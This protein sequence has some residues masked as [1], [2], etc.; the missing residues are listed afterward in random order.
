[1]I[2]S[3][4]KRHG[5]FAGMEKK[6]N[7]VEIRLLLAFGLAGVV[8]FVSQYFLKPAAPPT[9]AVQTAG[10]QAQPAKPSEA[11]S[12]VTADKP[13]PS[14][15]P[16]NGK[17][18]AAVAAKEIKADK[19]ETV[20]VETNRYL[21][22]FSN[23][24][25]VAR[26]WILKSF[27]DSKGKP[28]DVVDQQSLGK[29]PDVFSVAFKGQAPATDINGQLFKMER[30][31]DG[32]G[33]TF[34]YSDGMLTAHKAFRF[35]AQD[36]LVKVTSNI[37]ASGAALLH[38]IT[39]RGG[40]GDFTVISATAAQHTSRY[41]LTAEKLESQAVGDAK[42]GPISATGQYSF[43]AI[44][45]A[46]FAA[47]FLPTDKVAIEQTTYADDIPNSEGKA[48]PHVGL[49]VGNNGLNQ[50]SLFVGPKDT[51]LLEKVDPKLAQIVDWGWF[52]I[53]ARPLFNILAWTS[54]E[55]THNYGWAI[56]VVTIGINFLLFPGRLSGIKSSKKMQAIQPQVKAINDKYKNLGMRDPR[57]SEQ[58][59]ELMELYKKHDISV[60]GGC[61]PLLI[62]IPFLYAFYKVLSLSTEMRG[63]EWLWVSDLSRPET[64]ALR[65]LPLLL[66]ITQFLQQ[67]MTPPA[68]G[69][70]PS[71]Q[72][73]MMMM[74]LVMGFMFY[75][76]SSGLVLYWLTGNIVGIGQQWI[77]N[78]L[79]HTP[80][81]ETPKPGTSKK[82]RS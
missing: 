56:I 20:T 37:T 13:V 70:D 47:V 26:S 55:L 5:I 22:T 38:S 19:E 10:N 71:Q 78:K 74:P 7:S 39:W 72:K 1:M 64:L 81:V 57:K 66:I 68:P 48:E 36:Y 28:L 62:Q 29:V 58:Q 61:L 77:L 14:A 30:S 65:A 52:G 16:V 59:Q 79:T 18:P 44:E 60:A 32:L 63:A 17:T 11:A 80:A 51:K 21:V 75:G 41:D 12:P 45:D 34:D 4:S 69:M 15:K 27:K 46:Y 43:A 24:G 42:K 50:F 31:A 25:A 33:L 9:P 54:R 23:R 40:F 8:L 35:E 82:G 6:D 76:A 73:M 49:G 2:R 67:K 3:A 53:I